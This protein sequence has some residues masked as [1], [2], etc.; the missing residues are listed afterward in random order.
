MYN[1][2]VNYTFE[3][4]LLDVASISS[5]FLFCYFWLLRI[6]SLVKKHEKNKA[7]LSA[8]YITFQVLCK[9]KL[10]VDYITFQVLCKLKLSVDYITFQVLCKLKLSADYIT[11]QVLCKLK[12]SADYITFQV[13]C[14]L[15]LSVDYITFQVLCKLKF[16]NCSLSVAGLLAVR[17]SIC[18]SFSQKS[19]CNKE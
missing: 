4:S 9:L 7:E 13:L 6:N 14:K 2:Y 1:Y 17:G 10:S 18:L 3:V 19:G 11:F 12:P 5:V 15:K 16:L 8:D